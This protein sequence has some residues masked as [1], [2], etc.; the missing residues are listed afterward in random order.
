MLACRKRARQR[1]RQAEHVDH[2]D[3]RGLD[4]LDRIELVRDR[5]GR[6]GEVVNLVAFDNQRMHDVVPDQFEVRIADQVL[7][8]RLAAGE[9][10]VDA[11]DVV[12]ASDQ[13]VAQVTSE[14]SGTAGDEDCR[15]SF[16]Q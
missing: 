2:A 5:R 12:S 6:T 14:K 7:N 13:P 4:R 1:L 10:V 9:K 8:V 3:G 16:S 15:H 11:D